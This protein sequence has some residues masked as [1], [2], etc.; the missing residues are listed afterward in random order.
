MSKTQPREVA[1]PGFEVEIKSGGRAYD[2]GLPRVEPTLSPARA[3]AKA[4]ARK[5]RLLV[6]ALCVLG[7]GSIM[8]WAWLSNPN[9]LVPSDAVARVNGEYIYERDINRELDLTRAF[10]EVSQAHFNE[11]AE[12]PSAAVVLEDLISRKMREQDARKAGVSVAPAEVDA[13]IRAVLDGVGMSE[14]ELAAVFGKYNLKIDDLRGVL[15]GTALLRKY[16]DDYVLAGATGEQDRQTRRNDWL[17]NLAQTSKIDR[18]KPAGSGPAPRVGSE[19]PDFTLKDLGGKDV[20]LSG[21]RGRP[22]MVNFWAT[23]C[24]P[25]R[26]EIPVI[27]QLYQE[28]NT[29]GKYE[30]LGIGIQSVQSDEPTIRAFAAEFDM[31]FPVLIDAGSQV[32][33]LYHVLP[34][35]TSVFIDKDGIIRYIHIGQVDRALMEKWLLE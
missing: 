28:A 2:A 25:C 22:V 7:L 14:E 31:P 26:A 6:M 35:P 15:A 12:L 27:T 5:R 19:A 34:I 30:V 29:A 10:N 18:L 23:W 3:A 16:V 8:A 32:T 33:S 11:A 21:L 9:S 4:Q 1:D 24:P 13:E 17:T 20:K